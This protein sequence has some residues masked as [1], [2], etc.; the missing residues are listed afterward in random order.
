MLKRFAA[1]LCMALCTA[2]CLFYPAYGAAAND[3]L[4]IANDIIEWKKTDIGSDKYLIND[5]FLEQAGSTAGDW[6]PIGLGRL[7]ISDNNSGYLAVL[8]DIVQERYRLP[9]KL[10]SSKATEW[11]R[12]ALAVLAMGGDPTNF[13]TDENGQPI[14]LIADGTCDRGKT[15]SLGRQGINGWIWGL[16]ALDSKRYEIPDGAFYSRDDIIS[17]ILCRQLS[18]GGFA[19]SGN[20]S[21]PDITAMAVQAL[22]PYYNSEKRYSYM[23][24]ALKTEVNKTV[25]EVVDSALLC[26]SELQLET[27]DFLSW[28]TQNV[29]STDQ[30]LTS[31]C[32]LNI[33]PLSDERFIKNGKTLLDGIL[34]Y[35]MP[36]GGFAHSFKFDPENPAAVPNKSNSMAGE[37]TLYTVAALWRQEN[38]MRTLYDFRSEQ[39]EEL[40]QRINALEQEI[41]AIDQTTDENELK[42]LLKDFYSI[43]ESERCYVNGYWNLSDAAKARNI[44]VEE[45]A[46]NT[47]VVEDESDS[48]KAPQK[49]IFSAEDM[50]AAEQLPEKLT[51]EQ[52]VIVTTLLEKLNNTDDFTGKDEYLRK[53]TSAKAE[54]KLIQDEI[55]SLNA[56]ILNKLYPFDEITLSDKKTVDEIVKRYNAL[57]EYD[58]AKITG[59][60]DIIKTKTKLDNM[61]R[62]III[63]VGLCVLAIILGIILVLRIRRRRCRKAREM[64]ELSAMYEDE[65]P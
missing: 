59:S 33:D 63:A 35:Q 56:E 22:A 1:V 7:G 34:L 57:S 48:E 36:D 28:G 52:Y 62:G 12:I 39:S 8:K 29:E 6:Y 51:T 11:H 50:K 47:V 15:A 16:I 4:E 46:E 31:L 37:Q 18:D 2:L 53:L 43:T 45:I 3:A 42:Q 14:N 58:R 13:G 25:R 49:S 27:G 44:D 5:T 40:K 38:G 20:I 41:S 61:L 21:D 17:E 32:C 54:I 55:D 30:V 26:L 23:Q 60:G 10:S 9:E 19:L 64:E 65:E 24:K